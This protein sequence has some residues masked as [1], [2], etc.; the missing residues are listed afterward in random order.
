MRLIMTTKSRKFLISL[1]V[2]VLILP[3]WLV[4]GIFNTPTAKASGIEKPGMKDA[5]VNSSSS[6]TVSW[7]DKS[8]NE[9]EFMLE[10]KLDTEPI[11]AYLQIAVVKSVTM[12]NDSGTVYGYDD[13]LLVCNQKFNY[14]VRAHNS[15]DDVY[16]LY[17]TETDAKTQYLQTLETTDLSP[18]YTSK[19]KTDVLLMSFTMQSCLTTAEIKRVQVK[20]FGTASSD[21]AQLKLYQENS[22]LPGSF[23]PA[24]DSLLASDSSG[25]VG[26]YDFDFSP[27]FSLGTNT[28]R[29]Y[30]AADI[31][32]T[33]VNADT[34]SVQI[35]KG[36]IN[37]DPN[38]PNHSADSEWPTADWSRTRDVIID[39]TAPNPIL[40]LAVADTI[41]SDGSLH[42][43]WTKA[44]DAISGVLNQMVYRNDTLIA[45]LGPD[46][47]TYQDPAIGY[48][49]NGIYEYYIIAEDNADNVTIKS[50]SNPQTITV[51]VVAPKAPIITVKEA[52]TKVINVSF[53]G[54]GGPIDSYQI[55]I[56]NILA[57][58]ILATGEIAGHVYSEN[59]SVVDYG[60]YNIFV[61]AIGQGGHNDS[62][63]N[64]IRLS[65]PAVVSSASIATVKRVTKSAASQPA[66]VA[67]TSPSTSSPSATDDQGQIKGED[68]NNSAST[69]EEKVNWTPWIILFILI[70]LAGAATGGYF[71][72]FAGEDEMNKEIKKENVA[73]ATKKSN[74]NVK[75]DDGKPAGGSTKSRRW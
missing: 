22:A 23:D 52:G 61:R 58:T 18:L 27:D 73:A 6:I 49:P 17:S 67:I 15:T 43:N 24:A 25:S 5:S 75:K 33:A 72:W 28:A 36:K 56:N 35:L 16:S 2:S 14:R 13:T 46:A 47:N 7:K 68:Q 3:T 63:V 10:R 41:D 32:A 65:S 31:S 9:D 1:L 4:M 37:I 71:Y 29:F 62:S 50:D 42:L 74:N 44:N 21:I 55:Y 30:V 11:S 20:Y 59:I 8:D 45:T 54:F 51:L 66:Q 34:I 39:S 26:H 69:T 48:L 38:N 12:T 70:I 19:S 53:T 60:T 57:K 64:T 40:D